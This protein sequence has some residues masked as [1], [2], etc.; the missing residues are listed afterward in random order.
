MGWGGN[1]NSLPN[2]LQDLVFWNRA[3]KP[4]EPGVRR[5]LTHPT[6]APPSASDEQNAGET[7]TDFDWWEHSGG[8]VN[9]AASYT[10]KCV[11]PS[12][13]GFFGHKAGSFKNSSCKLIES[14]GVPVSP[15]SLYE[16]QLELRLGGK[17]PTW[18]TEAKEAF[19]FYKLNGYFETPLFPP[20]PPLPPASPPLPPSPPMPPTAPPSPSGPPML[21]PQPPHA[22]PPRP[23]CANGLIGSGA[24]GAPRPG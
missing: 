2:H 23:W 21:P 9:P 1:T 6:F 10:P 5:V 13:I 7:W 19:E 24:W 3:R 16:A 18:W 4:M 17:I 15:A 8:G 12:V 22:P 11:Y 14:P 20:S